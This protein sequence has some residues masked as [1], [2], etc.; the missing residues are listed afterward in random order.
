MARNGSVPLG[1]IDRMHLLLHGE[2]RAAGSAS[3]SIA[4]AMLD[5][6]ADVERIERRVRRVCAAMEELRWQLHRRF[7][8]PVWRPTGSAP[9]IRV[10][11]LTGELFDVAVERMRGRVDGKQPW[12]LE[13]LRGERDDAVVLHWF[14]PLVD[15]KGA[16]RLMACLGGDDEP[17]PCDKRWRAP[18]QALDKYDRRARLSLARAFAHNAATRGQR[19]IRSLRRV[20]NGAAAGRQRGIRIQLDERQSE[21]FDTSVRARANRADTSIIAFAAMRLLDRLIAKRGH[22][23]ERYVAPVPLSLDPKRGAVRLFGNNISIMMMS[24]DR[25]TLTDEAAAVAQFAAQ[26]RDIVR[27]RA[28]IGMLAALQ[29]LQPLPAPF[30]RWLERRPFDGQRASL[31]VSNPGALPLESFA[32]SSVRDAF[33][34]AATPPDPGFMVIGQRHRDRLGVTIGFCDGYAG[35]DEVQAEVP[36]FID[37]LMG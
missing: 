32:G 29:L 28:D 3:T 25:D 4:V 1:V 6:R 16:Y 33:V 24:L 27:G 17:P 26:R 11:P 2:L 35:Y 15:A 14:Q 22:R 36:R 31:L 34:F 13:V 37:D 20:A 12:R 8:R 7:T 30:T 5:G 10:V 23:P 21:R 9:P 19:P 18:E